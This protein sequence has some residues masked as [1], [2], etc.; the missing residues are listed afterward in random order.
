M[1][2]AIKTVK[3]LLKRN[4]CI[5]GLTHPSCCDFSTTASFKNHFQFERALVAPNPTD[6]FVNSSD[7]SVSPHSL[8]VAV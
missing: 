3:T 8:L 1:L 5:K 2:L 4:P 7:L 6:P